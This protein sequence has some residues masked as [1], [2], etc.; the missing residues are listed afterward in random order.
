[1][2]N[3]LIFD[4]IAV[5][6]EGYAPNPLGISIA[7]PALYSYYY[8]INHKED[9]NIDQEIHDY[10]FHTLRTARYRIFHNAAHDAVEILPELKDLPFICTM[11]VGHMVDENVISKSLDWLHKTYCPDSK[12]VGKMLSPVMKSI[13][14]THGWEWVPFEMMNE[15]AD[16][17]ARITMELFL[18]LKPLYEEQ[19]GP[20]WSIC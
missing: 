12:H 13:I 5:D 18:A 6:T 4:Y 3:C 10:L 2:D 15:Y 7:H 1:M 16:N 20:F 11:I 14:E 19:F 17:D 9:V 8:P